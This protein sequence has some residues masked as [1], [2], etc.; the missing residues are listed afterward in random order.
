MEVGVKSFL[1]HLI[2]GPPRPA[3]FVA[4][5]CQDIQNILHLICCPSHLTEKVIGDLKENDIT[6]SYESSYMDM[7]P[8]HHRAFVHLSEGICPTNEEDLKNLYL[9]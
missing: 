9:M 7:I 8:G 4:Y 3:D 2:K 6:P 5:F 1:T